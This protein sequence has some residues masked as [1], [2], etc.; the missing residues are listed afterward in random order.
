MVLGGEQI[1]RPLHFL[2]F[3]NPLHDELVRG[4]VSLA[5]DP[6]AI[7]L[8]LPADHAL[9]AT[10]EAGVYFVRISV[11]DPAAALTSDGVEERA[12]AQVASAATATA[13]AKLAELLAP[14]RRQL[15]CALEADARWLR[16][17]L[18]AE[19]LSE[20]F[21][22]RDGDWHVVGSESLCALL[23][24]MAH[25]RQG[26]PP[27]TVWDPPQ[28]HRDLASA[29]AERLRLSDTA[30]AKSTWGHRFPSFEHALA[31][32]RH[33]ILEEAQDAEVLAALELQDAERRLETARAKGNPA[34][35]S[36]AES[37]RAANAD[38]L[39]V[40]RTLWAER[41]A[42]LDGC[43]TAIR[44]L[45]PDEKAIALIRLRKAP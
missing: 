37:L 24:P 4:W 33:A 15:R 16:T 12:W 44:E 2:N 34:Q 41:I 14:Y 6:V 31:L 45:L 29:T 30:V 7:E 8:I 11:L 13:P 28:T 27:S 36:R 23:N 22:V 1:R 26:L 18:P 40:T 19:L 9:F 35:I 10:E 43:A 3:G 5:K 38:L 17:Q 25:G 20:A 32:R 21:R 42:W 39:H